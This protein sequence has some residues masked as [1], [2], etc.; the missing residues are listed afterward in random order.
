MHSDP[1]LSSIL[2]AAGAPFPITHNGKTYHVGAPTLQARDVFHKLVVATALRDAQQADIDLP[3]LGAMA[4]FRDD[5]KEK[6]YRPGA[7]KWLRYATGNR[8]NAIFL[9]ALLYGNHPDATVDLAE[10]L[11]AAEPDA[12][13]V[14]LGEVMPNFFDLL[15][16]DKAL[17]L[18]VQEAFT[19]GAKSLQEKLAS[20]DSLKPQGGSTEPSTT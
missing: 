7:E 16:A 9:A 13:S 2:G 3:G 6:L 20:L 10:E 15:A 12:V 4:A 1:L 17:P 18:P 11:I 19:R 8:S 14:A 5:Y